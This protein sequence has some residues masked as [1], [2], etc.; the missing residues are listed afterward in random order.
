MSIKFE[1]VDSVRP[2]DDTTLFTCSGMQQYKKLFKDSSYKHVTIGN[3]QPC[4]R[5]N[6][7]DEIGDETHFLYFNMIG[8]FS[9]RSMELEETIYFC[10]TFLSRIGIKPDWVTIH[11]DKPGW[12]SFYEDY[13]VEV[14]LDESCTWSDGE[15][16]GYCTEFYV[17]GIEIGNIVNCNGDC[18]DVG[19]GLER[20]DMIVNKRSKNELDVL[21][22]TIT[23]IIESGYIPGPKKQG[24]ILRKLL[25]MLVIKG[26]TIEH[27]FFE[28]EKLR[29][30]KLMVKYERLKNKHKDKSLEWW[31]DTH[32][33]DL[34][35]MGN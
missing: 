7:L 30:D 10:M 15:L 17:D 21:K 27:E 2:H 33:I 24:Y 22:D 18:I 26:G 3:V 5:L 29:Q 13:K 34:N 4:I 31:Y 16:G 25:R 9:F 20:L 14:R 1:T 6:D 28:S 32:G 23:K 19:F 11:P 12:R 8:M 35:L